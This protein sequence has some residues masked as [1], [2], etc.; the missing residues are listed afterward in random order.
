MK[1]T[2]PTDAPTVK[3]ADPP[4]KHRGP[5]AVRLNEDDRKIIKDIQTHTGAT[6]DAEVL[7]MGLR[8]LA[9]EL[10]VRQ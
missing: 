2:K 10:R 7:R 9:R 3:I 6:T 8:A 1:K 5:T 4:Q